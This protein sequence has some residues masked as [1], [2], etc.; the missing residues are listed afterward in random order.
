LKAY[1]AKG[2]RRSDAYQRRKYVDNGTGSNDRSTAAL[3]FFLAQDKWHATVIC[4]QAANSSILMQPTS[5]LPW[6]G[7]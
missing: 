6:F 3:I 2:N 7:G 1:P 4:P 5:F